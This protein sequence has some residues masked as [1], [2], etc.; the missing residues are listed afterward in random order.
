MTESY[1]SLKQSDEDVDNT[2]FIFL[3]KRKL[4]RPYLP[5]IYFGS[6]CLATLALT[7]L[8]AISYKAFHRTGDTITPAGLIPDCKSKLINPCV[9]D[10]D[11]MLCAVPRVAVEFKPHPEFSNLTDP[12]STQMWSDV[13][14]ALTKQSKVAYQC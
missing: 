7:I 14:K 10:S 11:Y 6:G 13:R 4:N 5:Y 12:I 2:S 8:C 3:Q 9:I 1:T